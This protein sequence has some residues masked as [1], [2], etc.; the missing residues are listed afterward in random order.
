MG[1]AGC[2]E[3]GAQRKPEEQPQ[4]EHDGQGAGAQRQ[5]DSSQGQA[6]ENHAPRLPCTRSARLRQQQQARPMDS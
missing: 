6:H 4:T 3:T 5:L 2:P 1:Q